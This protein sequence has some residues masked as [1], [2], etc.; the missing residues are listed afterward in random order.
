MNDQIAQQILDKT[1]GQIFGYQNPFSLEQFMRKFAFDVNLPKLVTDSTTGED[2][3]AQSTNPT[4][5]MTLSNARKRSEIDD[6]MIPK[7]PLQ[8]LEDVLTAW[9]DIN[10]T[11]TE[12]Q[13]DSINM[14]KSD[15][16]YNSDMVYYSQD[17]HFS[18]NIL[19]CDAIKGS[20]YLLA[21]QRSHSSVYSCRIEDSKECTQSFS[22][23]WSGKIANSFF[24]HDSY[25]LSDCM[26]CSHIGSKRFCIANMQFEEE[27]YNALKKQIIAWILSAN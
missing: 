18:K 10:F 22:V 15:N 1:M 19:F 4:K 16:I 17:I 21:S 3:W 12:R 26:F 7:R 13:I 25:D 8:S 14:A 9:N 6:W 11:S 20:E 27:E 24:I 5:F 2:T 23:S